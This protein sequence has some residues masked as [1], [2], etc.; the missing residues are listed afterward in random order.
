VKIKKGI[1]HFTTPLYLDSGRI[2]EP[3]ELAYETYGEL[4]EDR[5]NV[6]VVAHA[7]SGS[8]HAAGFY[9]GD[10]KPGW[11][12]GM[13][14][15]KKAIDTDRFFVICVNVIGSCFGS[16]SPR[17]HIHPSDERYGF[18]FPVVTIRDMVKAQIALFTR[19]G[20]YEAHAVIG[21][22][23]GG[24][25]ALSFAVHF[26]S[27]AKK[28][29]PLATTHATSPKV[30]AANKI[31]MEAIKNDP[32]FKSGEYSDD[33]IEKFGLSGL[34]VARMIGFLDYLS[35]LTM[36]KKFGRKY[37]D[38]DGLY[39]LFGRFEVERYLEYNGYN[40]P[41]WFD[42]LSYLY[43]LKAI[44]I[45]DIS[46]GYESLEK[47][48][49]GVK[50]KLY[51]IGFSGDMM[52]RSS[53]LRQL[54]MAMKSIGKESQCRFFEIDSAYGHDAFLVELYKFEEIVKDILE[55]RL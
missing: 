47:A 34:S 43:L 48:L 39:E 5:S 26:P 33:D 46:L 41:N 2:L 4:N 8:Q 7:L 21:G 53:E 15:S 31:M 37:V 13:I 23:M 10:R 28:I 29:I 54:D 51:P 49:N 18:K 36:D 32:V 42:P 44:S 14:G 27:F 22:S 40:F 38:T 3:Y 24:M 50:A 17:S 45:F 52:F 9:E 20:I 55:D 25:Q 12:D 35:P 1:E 16:T 6:I 19:L 30:I 11:W